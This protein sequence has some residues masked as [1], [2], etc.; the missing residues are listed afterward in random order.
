MFECIP[1]DPEAVENLDYDSG[2][3]GSAG[4][5]AAPAV[6]TVD[7]VTTGP[8]VTNRDWLQLS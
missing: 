6:T 7:A 3:A 5:D 4:P 1:S 2:R 8:A